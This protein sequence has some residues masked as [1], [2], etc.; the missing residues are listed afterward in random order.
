MWL[1]T[2]GRNPGGRSG[3]PCDNR[4]V[5]SQRRKDCAVY[6]E[7]TVLDFGINRLQ[8]GQID[9]FFLIR[10]RLTLPGLYD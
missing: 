9:G 3:I 8:P 10:L 4:P 6:G 7:K 1:S 2:L 5:P